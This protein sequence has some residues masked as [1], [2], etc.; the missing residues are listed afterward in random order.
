MQNSIEST[1]IS[2]LNRTK[3]ITK[4]E[5]ATATGSNTNS[6]RSLISVNRKN[7]V[8]IIDNL[9]PSPTGKSFY[10]KA[11]KIAQSDKEYFSW[12]VRQ[13]GENVPPVLGAPRV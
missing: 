5:L 6:I 3:G 7:G 4:E 12:A 13:L 10:K 11:Y 8:R 9:I 2:V 1:M